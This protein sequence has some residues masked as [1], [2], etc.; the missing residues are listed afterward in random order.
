MSALSRRTL[1]LTLVGLVAAG[2]A[3]AD[4]GPNHRVRQNRPISAGTSGGNVNDQGA[5]VCCSGTIG[6]LVFDSAKKCYWMS[7]NHVFALQNNGTAGQAINQPGAIDN[8][9]NQP[10]ADQVGT[11]TRWVTIQFSNTADNKVDGALAET[12]ST[13]AA[14][15]ILDI[16]QAGGDIISNPTVGLKVKKSGRTTGLTTGSVTGLNGTVTINYSNGCGQPANKPARFVGQ[17]IFS[18]MSKGGDSGSLIVENVSK[19][20]RGVALLFAGSNTATI[21]NPIA[22]ALSQLGNV[23]LANPFMPCRAAISSPENTDLY[24]QHAIDVQNRVTDRVMQIPGVVGT[25]IGADE[26]GG[27]VVQ[28][29]LERDDASVRSRIPARFEDIPSRIVVSGKFVAQ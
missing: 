2:S 13:N 27:Y 14:A 11:L 12:D 16:G 15:G 18:A 3:L 7:N 26:N 9:C 24:L 21:G 19:C 28:I 22:D 29:Y 6:S 5:G 1:G 10:A 23:S 8:G 4:G 17:I 20:P 25:S